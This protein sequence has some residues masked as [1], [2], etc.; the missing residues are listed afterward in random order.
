MRRR[1]GMRTAGAVS[2]LIVIFKGHCVAF[3]DG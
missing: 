1:G 3:T 2:L